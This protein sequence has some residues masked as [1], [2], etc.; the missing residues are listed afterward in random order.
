[1]RKRL[2]I[3]ILFPLTQL[4]TAS[5][6]SITCHITGEVEDKA[7]KE[8]ILSEM[9]TDMRVN[10]HI[11]IGIKDGRF[12]Y[13]LIADKLKSYN[14]ILRSE[15]EKGILRIKD[16][17]V[18]NANVHINIPKAS[19]M[20]GSDD[21]FK[22]ESDGEEN[23][24]KLKYLAFYDSINSIYKPKFKRQEI[25]RDSLN[26]QKLYLKPIMYE[27]REKIKVASEA[28]R[29][30]LW[31]LFP[32]DCYSELGKKTEEEYGNL[33]DNFHV[34]LA[35]WFK[36]NKCF[37]GLV[38]INRRIVSERLPK[39]QE[40]FIDIYLNHYNNYMP[41]HPYHLQASYSIA[42]ARLKVGKKYIDY[43]VRGMDGKYV[44]LSSLL[45]G[46]VIFINMWASWCGSCRVHSKSII[47][48]YEK[49][50]DKG[51]QVIGIAREKVMGAME[52]A[53]EKDRYPWVNLLELRDQ[54]H[55]W[56][57]NGINNA[58]GGGF[59]IDEKGNILA[60][61]PEG[62]ELEIILKEIL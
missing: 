16:F 61:Y 3:S 55:I 13:K 45:T 38:E 37:Y 53:I 52:T 60:V 15:Y 5:A 39:T 48:I 7:E 11:V 2:I 23:K 18:E 21:S 26:K 32:K 29:D 30:S 59:L 25:I 43:D 28:Q 51:F 57:K 42:A 14:I 46:K 9:G 44:K 1:M 27:L 50:K 17:I 35:E 62:D 33:I 12:S 8:V 19:A 49:Y 22:I 10:N 58:G 4:S 31:K 54:H 6:Q 34:E 36:T 24:M 47:P 40:K 56:L 20:D 41:E